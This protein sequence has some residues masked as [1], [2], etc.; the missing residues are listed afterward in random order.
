MPRVRQM[1][2]KFRIVT[3]EDGIRC[4]Q[5]H[6]IIMDHHSW[7]TIAEGEE[8]AQVFCAVCGSMPAD[9]PWA[10]AFCTQQ[11]QRNKS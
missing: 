4:L 10:S 7:E 2:G 11:C 5:R 1:S 3:D 8:I 9:K 6:V